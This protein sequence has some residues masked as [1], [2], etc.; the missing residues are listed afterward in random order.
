MRELASEK[1]WLTFDSRAPDGH[2]AVVGCR[3]LLGFLSADESRF[4]S[5]W[6]APAFPCRAPIDGNYLGAFAPFRLRRRG[7][8]LSTASEC[9]RHDG[10]R[11]A[12]RDLNC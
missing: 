8:R 11:P 1:S 3:T 4:S 5:Y 9:F 10:R 2:I 7:E 12:Q 6:R